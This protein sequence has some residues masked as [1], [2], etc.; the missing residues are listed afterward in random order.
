M[1]SA[2]A[3]KSIAWLIIFIIGSMLFAGS[4]SFAKGRQENRS[5]L[6]LNS[7]HKGYRWTD[8]IIEGIFSVLEPE[9][10]QIHLTVEDMD[11]KRVTA[12]QEYF[13]KLYEVYRYKFRDRK[14]DLVI[15]SDD[16][17]FRF[18]E[19]FHQQL[20]P[21]TP[22][23]FCGVNYFEDEMLKDQPL[24]TG[25]VEMYDIRG[26]IQAALRIHPNTKNIYI[27]NDKTITGQGIRRT[28]LEVTK[29][30]PDVNF[31]SL[32]DLSMAKI[33]DKVRQ[34]PSDSLVLFLVFFQDTVGGHFSYDES[35]SLIA[36]GS[37]VPIY[38]VW[39][40]YLGH[41]IVGGVLM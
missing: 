11:T 13:N 14:F 10:Q 1:K 36:A 28:L 20:F 17:A 12:D 7:Y 18:L 37:R 41:G 38:G 29:E 24:F 31:I 23:I 27:I 22:V 39:D 2:K 9:G 5:I 35:I 16:A 33:Q 30:F 25:V 19:Q 34:L 4:L 32:E 26:T 15:C 8:D 21:G 6:V 40:F 3:R